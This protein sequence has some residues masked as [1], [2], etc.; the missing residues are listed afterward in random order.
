MAEKTDVLWGY[1]GNPGLKKV[2]M[3]FFYGKYLEK[4]K[5]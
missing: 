2:K 4:V 1:L 3:I 5:K